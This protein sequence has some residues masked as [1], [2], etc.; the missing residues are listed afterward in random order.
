[1]LL[2]RA[3]IDNLLYAR[4]LTNSRDYQ[5]F[6]FQLSMTIAHE[7]VHFLTGTLINVSQRQVTPP[8]VTSSAYGHRRGGEAG[9]YWEANFLGG[10]V[11]FWSSP[12]SQRPHSR[13]A[14]EAI[15][16]SPSPD[17]LTRPKKGRS[18]SM[19]YI[20]E[21]NQKSK[22][23]R[24]FGVAALF[25]PGM[26]TN[27]LSMKGFQCQSGLFRPERTSASAMT[28]FAEQAA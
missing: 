18:V 26:K 17:K 4:E 20:E 21:F 27:T 24:S 25:A 7:I 3:L 10:F 12:R 11:E 13:E 15:L 1:M 2:H 8:A 28:T 19:S 6:K 23:D 5:V 9:R 22:S 14:G 16:F